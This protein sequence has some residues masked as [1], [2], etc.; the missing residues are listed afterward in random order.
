MAALT[1]AFREDS[2]KI[3]CEH[4][5]MLDELDELEAALA[6]LSDPGYNRDRE[7]R[8]KVA[9]YGAH[10]ARRLPGLCQREEEKLLAKIDGVSPQ[11]HYFAEEMK[12]QHAE[13]IVRAGG[14]LRAL[15]SFERSP[16]QDTAQVYLRKQ[17]RE[18][19]RALRDHLNLEENELS[20]FL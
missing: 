13:L 16:D 6:R 12:R 2:Q 5:V 20:G 3:H 14:F 17:G 18:L 19:T 9:A 8:D 15:E 11:L 4:E 10:L 7:L 1:H